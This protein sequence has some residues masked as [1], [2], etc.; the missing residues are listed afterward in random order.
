MT[1]EELTVEPK[2]YPQLIGQ[3]KTDAH[4]IARLNKEHGVIIRLPATGSSETSVRIEGPPDAVRKAKHELAEHVAKLADERSKDIIIDQK[5]HSN[6]IGKGGKALN[7]VRAKFNDVQINIPAVAEKSDV[8][9]IRGN[10]NDVEKCY[11]HLQQL[12]KEMQE[13]NYKEEMQIVKE[14][15]RIIIGKGGAFIKKIRDDTHTRID[16]P[17]NESESNA[18]VLTGK[19]EN[20]LKARKLIEDKIKGKPLSY[21]PSLE[22][23]LNFSRF[24]LIITCDYISRLEKKQWKKDFSKK[25]S[26]VFV[27]VCFPSLTEI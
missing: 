7:E 20:V 1:C 16:I 2:Y 21:F 15:H 17:S 19:Q 27:S 14:F 26:V 10:K 18:I 5:F 23:D 12:V 25:N 4:V 3:K 9:T 13:S 22:L 24:F 11:K 8:V 6:L